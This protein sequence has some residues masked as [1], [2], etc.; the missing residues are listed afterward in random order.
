MLAKLYCLIKFTHAEEL[1]YT[2]AMIEIA[3]QKSLAEQLIPEIRRMLLEISTKAKASDVIKKSL[4]V[5]RSFINSIKITV[6]N[7]A[8]GIDIEPEV[9]AADS[10]DLELDLTALFISIGKAAKENE[11]GIALILDEVQYLNSNELAALVAAMHKMQQLQLPVVLIGAG[12]P[13]LYG[14]LGDAKS[15]SERLF[16]FPPIG[17]LSEDESFRALKNPITSE[18]ESITHEAL[19]KIY[20]ITQGYPYFIQEWGYQSWNIAQDSP[21]GVQDVIKA[22][23]LSEQRLDDNFFKVRFHRLTPKEKQYLRAMA[24]L[25][26]DSQRS[27]DIANVMEVKISALGT[28][29]ENLIKKGMIYSPKYGYVAFTVPLFDE[30]MCRAIPSMHSII[31]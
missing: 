23:Q 21:I 26:A 19:S 13:T 27:A 14:I 24:S 5:L 17:P 28:I 2:T 31:E 18:G 15:Y 25:G 30:F 9:G 20:E 22:T 8:F 16:S 12:L 11:T 7:N 10:G 4:A 6:D 29:R 1:G 3:E